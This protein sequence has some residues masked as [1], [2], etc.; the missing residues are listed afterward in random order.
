MKV[1]ASNVPEYYE[2]KVYA[3]MSQIDEEKEDVEMDE[4]R[5]EDTPDL[6]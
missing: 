4:P 2:R 5:R 6:V 1:F 3:Y